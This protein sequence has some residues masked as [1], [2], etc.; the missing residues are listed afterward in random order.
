MR[1]KPLFQFDSVDAQATILL[2]IDFLLK[3]DVL[4]VRYLC[5]GENPRDAAILRDRYATSRTN[6]LQSD[7]RNRRRS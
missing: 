1:D 3:Q 6:N 7:C 2:A 4:N 5:D